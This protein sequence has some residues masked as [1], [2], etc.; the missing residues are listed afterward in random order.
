MTKTTR[1]EGGSAMQ[2]AMLIFLL[3]DICDGAS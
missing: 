1:L 3:V 2:F